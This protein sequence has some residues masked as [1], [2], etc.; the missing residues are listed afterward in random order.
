MNL[1]NIL[2]IEI[3]EQIPNIAIAEGAFFATN[4]IIIGTNEDAVKALP[5]SNMSEDII[6]TKNDSSLLNDKNNSTI[7]NAPEENN[8]IE[9]DGEYFELIRLEGGKTLQTGSDY[10]VGKK[11]Y[12][13]FKV[14]I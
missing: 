2:N 11:K 6:E 3:K 9:K 10:S 4:E 14:I 8:L 12:L 1:S 7:S 5:A 13:S